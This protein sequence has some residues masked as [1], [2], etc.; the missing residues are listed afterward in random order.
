MYNIG[1]Y[2]AA[3]IF[4][5]IICD[6][7]QFGHYMYQTAVFWYK[8]ELD[9]RKVLLILDIVNHLTRKRIG[10]HLSSLNTD[11]MVC[12]CSICV[13]EFM[14]QPHTVCVETIT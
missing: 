13:A 5:L 2:D 11:E 9:T 8:T 4:L 7:C 3:N 6:L 1:L 14:E 12:G 10:F